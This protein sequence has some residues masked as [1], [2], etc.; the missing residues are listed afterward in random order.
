ME[1]PIIIGCVVVGIV[2]VIYSLGQRRGETMETIERRAAGR[3][4]D[5]TSREELLKRVR[6]AGRPSI[7]ERAA[8]LLSRP[9]MPKSQ[10]DQTSLRLKLASA[11]MRAESAATV[12]L[13]SKTVAA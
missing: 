9:M 8:P 1:L 11:G 3:A 4:G 5:G 7:I 6:G 10:G 12:F 13:A 2:L